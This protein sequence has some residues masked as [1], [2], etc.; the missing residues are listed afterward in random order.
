MS[1][2]ERAGHVRAEATEALHGACG[3]AGGLQETESI[4]NRQVHDFFFYLLPGV[5]WSMICIMCI[6]DDHDLFACR[7]DC[8]FHS[9][10]IH[11]LTN[12]KVQQM[13]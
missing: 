11:L 13:N 4:Q 6:F 9:L 12:K 1:L 3:G 5:A 8:M 7:T 10:L 2:A